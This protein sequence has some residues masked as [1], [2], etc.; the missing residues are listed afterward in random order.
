MSRLSAQL[1]E[2]RAATDEA[3]ARNV[4]LQER[5]ADAEGDVRLLRLAAAPLRALLP[6]VTTSGP[7]SVTAVAADLKRAAAHLTQVQRG[8][9]RRERELA[10]AKRHVDRLQRRVDELVL[11]GVATDAAGVT[12]DAGVDGVDAVDA[13]GGV[14]GV[15]AVD[16]VGGVGGVG[17]VDDTVTRAAAAAVA[18]TGG[19]Y[20]QLVRA[21]RSGHA[22]ART[23]AQAQRLEDL[24]PGNKPSSQ[25]SSRQL[26]GASTT[27]SA[28][29]GADAAAAAASSGD[30][31]LDAAA[32]RMLP[33]AAA[34]SREDADADASVREM[35]HATQPVHVEGSQMSLTRRGGS[36]RRG[37]DGERV[38]GVAHSFHLEADQSDLSD[39]LGTVHEFDPATDVDGVEDELGMDEHFAGDHAAEPLVEDLRHGAGIVEDDSLVESGDDGVVVGRPSFR[40]PVKPPV[41]FEVR[42]HAGACWCVARAACGAG[43]EASCCVGSCAC[44]MTSVGIIVGVPQIST[45]VEDDE[46]P[47][48]Q[49]AMAQKRQEFAARLSKRCVRSVFSC[50][51]GKLRADGCTACVCMN[52]DSRVVHVTCCSTAV[53]CAPNHQAVPSH[54]VRTLV[55]L[56]PPFLPAAPRPSPCLVVETHARASLHHVAS[57]WGRWAHTSRQP[58]SAPTHILVALPLHRHH[59]RRAAAL[60]VEA[61]GSLAHPAA[62]SPRLACTLVGVRHPSAAPQRVVAG[63]GTSPIQALPHPTAFFTTAPVP[64]A[65]V[66][67]MRVPAQ[68]QASAATRSDG[69]P[70]PCRDG[71]GEATPAWM[72]WP[73]HRATK[74]APGPRAPRRRCVSIITSAC[75]TR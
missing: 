18:T 52:T 72:R 38:S 5:V 51:L 63:A 73:R 35:N 41:V 43:V 53:R 36:Y 66:R 42:T 69:L 23:Q 56:L 17:G 67:L 16:G 54:A 21:R 71:V 37:G 33:T 20:P 25:L 10:A 34:S 26:A 57:P 9:V 15:D 70:L 3:H 31:W 68:A 55:T 48:R 27:A 30:D 28:G 11:A 50:L 2:A 14:G 22:Q 1:S 4:A 19:S 7:P 45:G 12:T 46:D 61:S 75:A 40:T 44:M 62:S 29:G 59:S 74:R 6:P 39:D 60:V 58:P 64:Q 8:A 24:P 13:V 49:A 65:G 47:D 32:A